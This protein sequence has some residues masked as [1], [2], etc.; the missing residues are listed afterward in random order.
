MYSMSLIF[1]YWRFY[2]EEYVGRWWMFFDIHSGYI[3]VSSE[4]AFTET[5]MS[6]SIMNR[7]NRTFPIET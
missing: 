4:T 1:S 5:T 6:F 3:Y 7:H 2:C